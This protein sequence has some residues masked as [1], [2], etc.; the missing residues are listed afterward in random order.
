M[1]NRDFSSQLI[2]PPGSKP[3]LRNK[4]ADRDLGWSKKKAATA[5]EKNRRRL[6][7]LQAKLYADG[8]HAVLVVLQGID[9]A[10]KDGTIRHVMTALNP[11]GCTVTSFKA[12]SAEELRH[13]Y[14]W[15]IHQNVPGRGE[16]GVFNRSH[17][18]DVLVVRVSELVPRSI[19]SERYAQINEF[20]RLLSA[21]G[22][23]IVKFFL[24]ISQDEQ[25]RRFEAR[26]R[27]PRKRW[28]F[29]PDDLAKRSQWDAY[30]Q[31]FEAALARC[32]TDWAPWYLIPADHKWLRNLAVSQILVRELESLPLHYPKP[33]F[34]P[35]KVRVI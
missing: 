19:W 16:I 3:R 21:N 29:D 25:K 34:D 23:R 28:K 14:L 20:E 24:H 26:I 33:S 15:R 27:D 1:S 6:E 18:E 17:Y 7:E 10:G 30:R 32:S 31:A 35:A 4:D 11:Q 9:G 12:P 5:L 13:D 22:V 8:R 2:V